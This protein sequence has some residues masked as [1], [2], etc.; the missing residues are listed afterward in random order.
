M[1]Y[2]ANDLEL[3]VYNGGQVS[4]VCL[5]TSD[6]CGTDTTFG[7]PDCLDFKL[8]AGVCVCADGAVTNSPRQEYVNTLEPQPHLECV[9]AVTQHEAVAEQYSASL[10]SYW[11]SFCLYLLLHSQSLLVALFSSDRVGLL[12]PYNSSSRL[13]LPLFQFLP[14]QREW[15]FLFLASQP[16]S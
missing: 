13:H 7:Q 6:N 14:T 4:P 15:I 1:L 5:F 12:H 16:Y 11:V 9:A 2:P 8:G 10:S 3:G